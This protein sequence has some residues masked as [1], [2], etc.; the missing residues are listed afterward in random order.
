MIANYV[1]LPAVDVPH[2]VDGV[3][4]DTHAEDF[5]VHT[6]QV[7]EV[8]ANFA[9]GVH[10]DQAGNVFPVAEMTLGKVQADIMVVGA[11][12]QTDYF[13]GSLGRA[14]Y[15]LEYRQNT[16]P[17]RIPKTHT[18]TIEKLV[19]IDRRGALRKNNRTVR[20]QNLGFPDH[21][22]GGLFLYQLQEPRWEFRIFIESL[23]TFLGQTGLVVGGPEEVS[24]FATLGII[25]CNF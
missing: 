17:K 18:R 4:D 10:L 22:I 7:E 25:G 20:F 2:A 8:V 14:C 19:R 3:P 5:T 15:R 13:V 1:E 11:L 12:L 16:L 6:F 21:L 23:S 9:V 24:G